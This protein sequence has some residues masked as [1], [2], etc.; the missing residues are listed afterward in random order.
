MPPLGTN[1]VDQAAVKL[2]R[3]WIAGMKPSQEIIHEWKMSDFASELA[4]FDSRG[5][6]Y[7]GGRRSFTSTGCVQCHKFG[8]NG[9][10]VGPDLSGIGKRAS[11]RDLLEAILEPSSH[12]VE[13]FAIPG[14]TPPLSTMPPGMVNV[15]DKGEVLD[16]VYY[17]K[18]DGRPRV[19]ALVTEYRH[20]SHADIIVSRLLQTD[21]LDGKGNAS[22][23]ELVSLYTDQVP[24]TDTSRM[25]AASHR[26]PIYPSIGEALTLGTG[27][28]AVDGVLLIAEHGDYPRSETGNIQYPKRR[29]WD[30]TL[31]VFDESG[32]SVPVFVDKHLGDNWKDAKYLHDS[33]QK[34]SIPLM[35]GSSL[36]TSWRKPAADVPRD[37]ELKEIVALSYHTT[38]AYGFHALEII[39]AL[40]EQRKGGETGIKAVHALADEEVWRAFDEKRFDLELLEAAWS[41]QTSP[42]DLTALRKLVAKPRLFTIEYADGL[43][44][45]MLELN[46]AVNE[47]TAA[48]RLKTDNRIDSSLFW[49]QEGRPGMHFTW[50]LHGI[51]KMILTG[52][53]SWNAERTLYT[54]GTLDA[55]LISVKNGARLET[56]Y[57][58]IPYQ[59]TWRWVEPPPP[60]PMR[61]WSEQ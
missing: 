18:R 7:L 49:T 22:P 1:L 27:T 3:D 36:P 26:F 23:L 12:I 46:G 5:H 47:W 50:L 32:R 15:L 33:A 30:E 59:P 43:V 51:E 8:E 61:P 44:A 34:R 39:Q 56:P 53:P 6:D 40:A 28:L 2:L 35:A 42:K 52:K 45:H 24:K 13:G 11:A 41:R 37:A 48:W 17:L 29:F 14:T 25:L 10:S 19:A 31:K 16:L 58:D 38:D 20:N 21:T 54:S 60:P 9:G 57:L 4:A 55:F